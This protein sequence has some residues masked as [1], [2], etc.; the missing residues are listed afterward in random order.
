MFLTVAAASAGRIK[1]GQ[2]RNYDIL[3][4]SPMKNAMNGIESSKGC[5]QGLNKFDDMKGAYK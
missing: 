5:T 2:G 1:Q 3:F 4:T